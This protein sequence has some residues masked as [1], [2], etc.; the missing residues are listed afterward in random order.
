MGRRR[1]RGEG[2]IRK[3]RKA[4]KDGTVYEFW[5]GQVM[6]G[7]RADGKRD[8]RTV[9]G[10]T[11]E[12]V[13]AAIAQLTIDR[14]AGRIV[15]PERT[16]LAEYLKSWL[17][18]HE[19][20]GNKG[21]GLRP[22]TI[23]NYRTVIEKHVI[24][25]LGTTPLQQVTPDHLKRLYQAIEAKS[26]TGSKRM[27]EMAHNILHRAFMDAV[28]ERKLAENPCDLI[29]NPPRTR[30][31]AEDRPRLPKD[32]VPQVLEKARDTRYYLP[33]LVAMATGMR[34]NEILGLTWDNV[35][36]EAGIIRVRQQWGKRKDG[37]WGLVP[38]KTEAGAREIPIPPEVVDALAAHK[39]TQE[40]QGLGPLV[41][42][43]GDG[44]PIPPEQ[45]DAAWKRVRED[46]GLPANLRLHDLRGSYI[47]WLAEAK[48]DPK[49]T[50]QL[51][52]HKD[53]KVTWALY[54]SVTQA[55]RE[56]AAQAIRQVLRQGPGR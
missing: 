9:S 40:A 49:A 41:F 4:R 32:K 44:K 1:G 22:N 56:E 30:Y 47:T 5:Q 42:D 18:Y 16:T 7:Y 48:V 15:R 38:P 36:L 53:V 51:A 11:R 26:R 10:R 31:R 8:I 37:S 45:L 50:A 23:R 25:V 17:A 34:R 21:A 46:L 52:G 6:V 13:A 29:A 24:P 3:I 20:H 54:Q 35:D 33:F 28:K 14:K 12:E 2:S 19:T 43:R 39:V 55:M 27:A